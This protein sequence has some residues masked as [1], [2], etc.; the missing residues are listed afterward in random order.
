MYRGSSFLLQRDYKVHTE[1]VKLI[2]KP[3]YDCLL[4]IS[5][6]DLSESTILGKL[7]ELI[8]EIEAQYNK[9]KNT[10]TEKHN[11]LKIASEQ[12]DDNESS[13][14][15]KG[16]LSQTLVTKILMGALGCTP[17]YDRYFISGLRWS[18][19]N[20]KMKFG[21]D[22]Y[23][24]NHKSLNSLIVFYKNNSED[25]EKLRDKYKVDT[26]IPY[27]QM[28]LLDMAFWQIGYDLDNPVTEEAEN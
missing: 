27:P 24:S 3:E 6:E 25:L 8:S 15:N 9:F 7:D 20:Y 2:L 28:K 4:G 10:Q 26:N 16:R 11:E 19:K 21:T 17:A 12:N 5:Y 18:N 23:T 1:V 13:D 14:E 22:F